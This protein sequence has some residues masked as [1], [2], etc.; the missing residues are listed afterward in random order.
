[1]RAPAARSSLQ[2]ERDGSC[3]LGSAK[4]AAANPRAELDTNGFATHGEVCPGDVIF[5]Y[6]ERDSHPGVDS[7]R[8]KIQM[9]TGEMYYY[10]SHGHPPLKMIPPF[11]HITSLEADGKPI[12]VSICDM[13]AG[14]HYLA[15][16]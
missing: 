10:T 2:R 15:I 11:R 4:Y 3:A 1:M 9:H 12:N 8:F 5:H 13:E 14:K 7:V 16:K 6:F